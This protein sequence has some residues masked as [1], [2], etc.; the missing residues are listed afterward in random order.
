LNRASQTIGFL[1]V[2]LLL[3]LATIANAQT[4]TSPLEKLPYSGGVLMSRAIRDGRVHLGSNAFLSPE[5]PPSET[6]TPAPCVLPNV[7][8]FPTANPVNE[9]PVVVNPK[10]HKQLMSGAND[11]NCPNVQGFY[12]SNDGG[13]TWSHFCMPN[14]ASIGPGAGDPGVGY[15]LKGNAYITGIDFTQPSGPAGIIFQKS[16]NNGKT[17]SAPKKAVA[18]LFSGGLTDKEWLQIDTTP[19]SRW[20][21]WLYISVTQFDP[22]SNSTISVSHSSN[23]GSS[24]KTVAVDKT[25][26]FPTVDQFSDIGID[27]TGRVYL[28]WMRCIA[29]GTSGDC[30]GTKA[31]MLISVS[32]DGGNTWT[33]PATV[34]TATLA[35][36]PNACCFY[37]ALPVTNNERVS[38][39]PVIGVDNSTGAHKGNL[40][41]AYYN[42]TGTQMKLMVATSTNGG[43][44]WTRKPVAPASAK[45]DQFFQWLNVS[46]KGVVGVSWD[47][48]RNDSTDTNYESFAA[49]SNNGGTSFSKNVDLSAAPSNPLNDGFGGFFLGDYTGN[50]WSGANTLYVTYTDTS[51]GVDQD[52]LAGYFR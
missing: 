39:I 49:F 30:A 47:D 44:T 40:Y 48:R 14:I 9:T 3:S 18:P 45:G 26:T 34:A 5:L 22:N 19:T 43:K 29:N 6:C 27:A 2:T 50:Y 51:T 38:N 20:P 32:N 33:K 28:T 1:L 25:Q 10:N 23:G 46:N 13:A 37:G 17:W 36:D 7:N 16:T 4:A 24:W 41:V 11:Y 31:T 21:N 15:D 52:F 42:W 8:I 35:P 12:N